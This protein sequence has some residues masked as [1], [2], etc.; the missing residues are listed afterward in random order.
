[1]AK[2]REKRQIRDDGPKT[3]KKMTREERK[4]AHDRAQKEYEKAVGELEAIEKKALEHGEEA[5]SHL[6]PLTKER[7]TLEKRG[8]A[9]TF[10]GMKVEAEAVTRAPK[11][12]RYKDF[13][14]I[15][16]VMGEPHVVEAKAKPAGAA[17]ATAHERL[18]WK[19]DDGSMFTIDRPVRPPGSTRPVS[20]DRPHAEFHGPG[21]ERLDA[22]GIRVPEKS[23]SA[24][25]TITDQ[26]RRMEH[27]FAPA[28]AK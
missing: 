2:L 3:T 15:E 11:D 8:T 5:V 20:A 19:F 25:I 17:E 13:T 26:T 4:R 6:D 7:T 1:L 16:A 14:E 18:I 12:L 10:T 21:G 28:R 27:F 23:I 24:H 22:Q 9:G